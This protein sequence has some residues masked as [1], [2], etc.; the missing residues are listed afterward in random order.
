M[1][2]R[3]AVRSWRNTDSAPRRPARFLPELAQH[4]LGSSQLVVEDSTGHVEE[5]AN[6]RIAHRVADGRAFLAGRQDVLRAEHGQLLRH[7]GL[8]EGEQGL[9][10]L[11]APVAGAEDLEDPDANGMRQGL[12]ELGLEGLKIGRTLQEH[13]DYYIKE[14]LYYGHANGARVID[15]FG[16][17]GMS[18]DDAERAHAAIRRLTRECID[19]TR[20]RLRRGERLNLNEVACG[21]AIGMRGVLVELGLS[22][23]QRETFLLVAAVDLLKAYL[24]NLERTSTKRRVN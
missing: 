22:L 11:D 5:V 1:P 3:S 16:R 2:A 17:L 10:L 24:Q 6:E 20:E 8:V 18:R 23:K 4:R 12:E 21:A 7:G 15:E 9:E 19:V 13:K 14:S